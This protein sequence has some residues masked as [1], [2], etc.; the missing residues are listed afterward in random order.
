MRGER[1]QNSTALK[2]RTGQRGVI[3][4]LNK[5]VRRDSIAI[6]EGKIDDKPITDVYILGEAVKELLLLNGGTQV[7]IV[8]LRKVKSTSEWPEVFIPPNR[9]KRLLKKEKLVA[10]RVIRTP[11]D[12]IKPAAR[13]SMYLHLVQELSQTTSADQRA[14][15]NQ[16]IMKVNIVAGIASNVTGLLDS[17][18][19]DV[20]RTLE[21]EKKK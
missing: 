18:A 1:T 14:L 7:G 20:R 5:R 8:V 6:L 2:D 11:I 9:L 16:R 15:L 19:T 4:E 12:V 13:V 10:G 21:S 3:Q 17:Y